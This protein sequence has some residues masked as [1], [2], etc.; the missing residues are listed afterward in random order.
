MDNL[1]I[2]IAKKNNLTYKKLNMVGGYTAYLFEFDN[3]DEVHAFL[4]LFKNRKN[5]YVDF[6]YYTNSIFVCD[7]EEHE[8]IKTMSE[9][10]MHLANIFCEIIH[11]GGTADTGKQA[12][13]DFCTL[14]PEYKP[15]FDLIYN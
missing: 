10:K 7:K 9:R 2:R 11:N 14:H 15:A 13:I 12:Q 1:I 6:N 3:I 8:K 4:P 5:L